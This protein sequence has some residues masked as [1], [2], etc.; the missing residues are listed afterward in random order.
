MLI[1]EVRYDIAEL[2]AKE[3]TSKAEVARSLGITRQSLNTNLNANVV[4]KAFL[5]T[6]EALGYDVE[7]K[8]VKR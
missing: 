2:C 8:Y 1:N 3:K 7:I 6:C 4:T 5:A